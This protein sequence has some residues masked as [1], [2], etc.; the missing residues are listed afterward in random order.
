MMD[1]M[2]MIALADCITKTRY[3]DIVKT[4]E[5]TSLSDHSSTN[6]VQTLFSTCIQ[7]SDILSSIEKGMFII[8]Q[9]F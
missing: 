5:G 4:N 3:I 6:R 9:L 2:P 7:D 8:L 1:G